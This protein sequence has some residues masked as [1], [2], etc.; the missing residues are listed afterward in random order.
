M[1]ILGIYIKEVYFIATCDIS[2]YGFSDYLYSFENL[3]K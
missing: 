2:N 1:P 3:I